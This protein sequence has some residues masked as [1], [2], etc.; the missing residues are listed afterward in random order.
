MEELSRTV[1][2]RRLR[3]VFRGALRTEDSRRAHVHRHAAAVPPLVVGRLRSGPVHLG[4]RLGV[5]KETSGYFERW[6]TTGAAVLHMR[7]SRE[8]TPSS[9]DSGTMRPVRRSRQTED[10]NVRWRRNRAGCSIA[11]SSGWIYGTDT[12]RYYSATIGNGAST[13][14][15]NSKDFVFDLPVTVT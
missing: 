12:R 8:T 11:S 15:L 10:W 3:A 7:R 6:S 14:R 1:A 5:V 2:E 13:S 9:R 4:Y